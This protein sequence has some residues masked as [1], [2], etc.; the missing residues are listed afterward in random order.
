MKIPEPIID[1]DFEKVID[2][3]FE[4][5]KK[6]PPKA[7]FVIEILRN[8]LEKNE[9]NFIEY[10]IYLKLIKFNSNFFRFWTK[11]EKLEIVQKIENKYDKHLSIQ[12]LK[13]Y[14]NKPFTVLAFKLGYKLKVQGYTLKIAPKSDFEDETIEEKKYIQFKDIKQPTLF[15]TNIYS[16]EKLFNKCF[17]L[18]TQFLDVFFRRNHDKPIISDFYKKGIYCLVEDIAAMATLQEEKNEEVIYTVKK[19]LDIL[20]DLYVSCTVILKNYDQEDRY[21]SSSTLDMLNEILR[22]LEP[23]TKNTDEKINYEEIHNK[24]LLKEE[25]T[26]VI[27]EVSKCN[28]IRKVHEINYIVTALMR[29]DLREIE[30]VAEDI[31]NKRMQS[32]K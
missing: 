14:L 28:D 24:L 21:V 1:N 30:K 11:K 29:E 17:V 3:D 9:I 15:I 7:Y 2:F 5:N 26:K 20:S 27:N 12:E 23:Y 19:M 4:M 10:I 13:E 25:Q 31:T 32:F 22:L 18:S 8:C 16:F 6:Y